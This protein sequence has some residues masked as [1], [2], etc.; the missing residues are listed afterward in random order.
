MFSNRKSFTFSELRT[1][2]A[3]EKSIVS[4][5]ILPPPP[6]PTQNKCI[7]FK[8]KKKTFFNCKWSFGNSA[9]RTRR[10]ATLVTSPNYHLLHV[11]WENCT[12]L[13]QQMNNFSF[14]STKTSVAA[15]YS[16]WCSAVGTTFV[17]QV[18]S[19]QN[20]ETHSMLL[21]ILL[22]WCMPVPAAAPLSSCISR[23]STPTDPPLN[24]GSATANK[25]NEWNKTL[26][27]I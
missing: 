15:E 25:V 22:L 23:W 9:T 7:V 1:W 17:S 10:T 5:S 21:C 4:P 3:I 2:C 6:S 19:Q 18:G 8:V 27:I 20:T 14:I 16:Q 26:I 24:S 11:V 13:E 12:V